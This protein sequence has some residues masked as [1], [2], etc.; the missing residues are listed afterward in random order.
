[1]KRSSIPFRTDKSDHQDGRTK[2]NSIVLV[3]THAAK[4]RVDRCMLLLLGFSFVG[5]LAGERALQ[6]RSQNRGAA[7]AVMMQL[8]RRKQSREGASAKG[9]ASAKAVPIS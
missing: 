2:S 5:L 6:N 9:D 3:P 7:M 1:M 4:V 8:L